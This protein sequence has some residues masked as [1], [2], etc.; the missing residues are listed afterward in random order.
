MTFY[1]SYLNI[2]YDDTYCVVE[3]KKISEFICILFLKLIV[4]TYDV[5]ILITEIRTND[6]RNNNSKYSHFIDNN[7]IKHIVSFIYYQIFINYINFV[8]NNTNVIEDYNSNDQ[9]S[10]NNLINEVKIYFCNK[11]K[12]KNTNKNHIVDYFKYHYKYFEFI[13]IPSFQL[14]STS[15]YILYSKNFFKQIFIYEKLHFAD[16]ST[17]KKLFL[18]LNNLYEVIVLDN[19]D[20]KQN[21]KYGNIEFNILYNYYKDYITIKRMRL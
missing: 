16:N 9:E 19:K 5:D 4:Y 15:C 8:K 1:K 12:F 7:Y 2:L 11:N 13:K 10:Y 20:N 17:I 21:I 3:M 6:K 18:Q 14:F